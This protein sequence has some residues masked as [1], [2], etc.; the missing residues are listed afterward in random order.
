M[1]EAGGDGA[2]P[3]KRQRERRADP[4]RARVGRALALVGHLGLI[5][6]FLAWFTVVAPPVRV[7][8][9][10]PLAAL[11]APLLLSLRGILH[12]RRYTHQWVSFLVAL[13]FLVGVDVWANPPGEGLAWLGMA[14][15]ALALAQFVGCVTFAR[16]TSSQSGKRV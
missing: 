10:L 9:L 14:T 12:G 7:P 16:Y 1:S 3:A 11:L 4:S 15:V 8:R 5:A 2:G 13:Y 6:L